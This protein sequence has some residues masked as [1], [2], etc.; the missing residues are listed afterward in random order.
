M[1]DKT[2]SRVAFGGQGRGEGNEMT[3]KGDPSLGAHRPLEG[4][5]PDI[6]KG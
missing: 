4:T 6:T 2:E 1:M 3:G 5:A